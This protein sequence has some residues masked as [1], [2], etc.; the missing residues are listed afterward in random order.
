VILDGVKSN[1]KVGEW[2]N[3]FQKE[4]NIRVTG[5]E[6]LV[7]TVSIWR[8]EKNDEVGHPKAEVVKSSHF[9]F[10]DMKMTWTDK[11]D[12]IFGVYLKP[13]QQLKYLNSDSSHTPHCFKA[14][15]KGVFAHLASL[16]SLTNDSRY[17][18]IKELYPQHHK[19][20]ELAGLVPKYVQT[21][22]EVLN[23]NE[24]KEK[25]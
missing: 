11:G 19:A 10:L 24:E 3:S 15:T 20:L 22:Q 23:L 18:T 13:G 7:F 12:L 9:P 6:G 2:L 5:Y 21:L 4:V 25:R 16:T 1:A 14:I 17:K 8:E